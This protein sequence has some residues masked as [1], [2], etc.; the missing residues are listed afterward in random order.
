VNQSIRATVVVPLYNDAETIEQCLDGLLAQ[1]IAP[2]LKL[3]VVNDGSTDDGARRVA[4]YPAVELIERP[5]GGP[6]A[7]RNTGAAAAVGDFLLFQ[8]ADA[9]APP[10]WARCM[11]EALDA[12]GVVAATGAINNASGN[13]LSR[14]V[15]VEIEERYAKLSKARFV[16]FFATVAVGFRRDYFRSLGGF[17]EDFLYNEDVELAYR[18]HDLGG[19][20]VFVAEP[21]L[22]HYHP[23]GWWD[24]FCMKFW[25]G[26]WRMR[27]YR[28]YP[29]KVV[30]DSW[31]PQT[32]KFQVV[33]SM[34][35]PLLLVAGWWYRESWVL[36]GSLLLAFIASAFGMLS[37]TLQVRD[38]GALLG[39]PVFLW[40]RSVALSTAVLF[41]SVRR[42][43]CQS[44][45][46]LRSREK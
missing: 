2:E 12:P 37:M 20:I 1:D 19:R 5:N 8:D 18:I 30:V 11:L 44:S 32:L 42:L 13:L 27:L 28:L 35:L 25:R 26:V 34:L 22:L 36:A 24:Y 21:R 16:D 45:G 33:A 3:V 29:G 15:Q 43:A 46:P 38:L 14:L 7:A 23:T 39:L 9:V 31:T 41:E 6:G 17:R 4:R 10:N 40:V